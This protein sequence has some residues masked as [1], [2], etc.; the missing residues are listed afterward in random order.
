[1]LVW[2][3]VC[4]SASMAFLAYEFWRAPLVDH[5][6]KVIRPAKKLSDLFKRKKLSYDRDKK[7]K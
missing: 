2:F 4:F 3:I 6:Y 5:N 7:G 1:M